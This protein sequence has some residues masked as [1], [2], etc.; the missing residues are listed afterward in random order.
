MVIDLT[1]DTTSEEEQTSYPFKAIGTSLRT[2]Q[3]LL[4]G[5]TQLGER[6]ITNGKRELFARKQTRES[7]LELDILAARFSSSETETFYSTQKRRRDEEDSPASSLP[8]HHGLSQHYLVNDVQRCMSVMYMKAK[9]GKR[10]ATKLPRATRTFRPG[11]PANHTAL[12]LQ[13]LYI[14]KLLSIDGPPVYFACNH[15]T[16]DVDFNFEFVS[17]YKMH[18]GVTPVDASFHAGCS[19][20]TEKCDLNICTCPSQEEGSDQR[21]VPYKVG[22]NGAV[23]LREDFMERKSMIYEC[24]MLCSCSS[25]C[26]NR[27]VERG[28]KVRLEIFETRNRGF[29]LRS[30]NSIQAGQYIDCYLGELL[31]KSEADNREKAISNK[32]SYL[33]SL[34]FLVDDEEVYVVDGRKFGSVT[35]FMNHSCNPNCKMFPVSHKHAD[36]RIFGLAFFALTNIPAGTELTFDYHPN[37]NPIKDGKDIDPDAV[38]CLCEERNC[39]GQLWP[40]QRKTL[41]ED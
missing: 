39:R 14:E 18:K 2:S 40:S 1:A 16:R 33:F 11:K 8:P 7:L 41:Q 29:G 25:T 34:D 12:D 13:N 22:D 24:S 17:C 37:W 9:K 4:T 10:S 19:C 6:N 15:A 32:A 21:I 31:T 30:K 36:Q 3:L 28:R 38:K 5:F 23:V 35:R 27:V 26:M 20:F